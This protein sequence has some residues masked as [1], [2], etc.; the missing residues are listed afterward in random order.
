MVHLRVLGLDTGDGK[1]PNRMT[2]FSLPRGRSLT[3]DAICVDSFATSTIIRILRQ[4]QQWRAKRSKY[5]ALNDRHLFKPIALE[6]T[7]IF[8]PS[9]RK[10]VKELEQRL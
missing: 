8:G 2:M 1:R 6:T 10:I 3:W 5:R 7:C 4:R 9:T